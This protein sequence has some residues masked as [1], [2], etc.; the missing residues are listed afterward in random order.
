MVNRTVLGCSKSPGILTRSTHTLPADRKSKD[1]R[2]DLK[3]FA[4]CYQRVCVLLLPSLQWHCT[5]NLL[6]LRGQ[7]YVYLHWNGS[8][9]CESV[10]LSA[11]RLVE[12][13]SAEMPADVAALRRVFEAFATFGAGRGQRRGEMEGVGAPAVLQHGRLS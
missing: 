8:K 5:Y 9:W 4:S 11:P 1:G 6:G 12:A 13:L 3:E 2:L 7:A 10:Q